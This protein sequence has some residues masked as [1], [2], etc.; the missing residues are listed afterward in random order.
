MLYERGY[1]VVGI[2]S[3]ERA[4][5][6]ARMRVPDGTFIVGDV[7]TDL[8]KAEFD[9]VTACEIIE[10]FAEADQWRLIRRLRAVVRPRGCLVLS[11]PNTISLESWAG[12]IAASLR[13]RRWDHGD[14]SH[15]KVHHTWSVRRMLRASGFDVQDQVGFQLIPHRPQLLAALAYR[16]VHGPLSWVCYDVILS[17]V[18]RA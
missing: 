16:R 2:D 18:A 9:L 3:N 15:Q 5:E 10:H 8:P 11:T 13:G 4:I 14:P 7:L 12:K 6:L 17:A 1:K